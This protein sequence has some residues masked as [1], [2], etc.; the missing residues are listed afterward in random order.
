MKQKI[1]SKIIL[2]IIIISMLIPIILMIIGSFKTNVQISKIPPDLSL[3]NLT[4]ENFRYLLSKNVFRSF[5]NSLTIAAGT[6]LLVVIIDSLAGYI[7]ARKKFAGKNFLFVSLLSTMMIPKQILM[8]PSFILLTKIG[9]YDTLLGVI[10]SSAALPFGVF[11]LKQTMQT[12]PNE[13]FEA[14]QIDGC[15]ELRMFLKVALPLSKAPIAAL[16]IF[17]FVISWN[18]FMWQLVMLTNKSNHTLPLFV[19]NLIAEKSSVPAYQFAGAVFATVPMLIIFLFF[20]RFFIS[21]ITVGA[22]K[23]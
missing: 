19:A 9:L 11:L 8:V 14:A 17:V 3:F 23:G 20:Q 15:S 1:L 22:V 18:D 13:I 6:T 10:L 21:G 4:L 7:F 2:I 5:I 12:L 16:S